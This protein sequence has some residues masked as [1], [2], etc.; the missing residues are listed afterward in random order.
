MVLNLNLNL[1]LFEGGGETN[2]PMEMFQLRLHV[3]A[4]SPPRNVLRANRNAPS[5]T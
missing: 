2:D 3:W 5:V 1:N 4:D